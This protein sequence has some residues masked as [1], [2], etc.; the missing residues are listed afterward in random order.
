MGQ[1]YEC[2]MIYDNRRGNP[3]ADKIEEIRE[4][5]VVKN[6]YPSSKKDIPILKIDK[7]ILDNS[8][9]YAI[10]LSKFDDFSNNRAF[11]SNIER[12]A[13]LTREYPKKELL[14]TILDGDKNED[15]VQKVEDKLQDIPSKQV[16]YLRKYG[17]EKVEKFVL[18]KAPKG[19]IKKGT[20]MSMLVLAW[21]IFCILGERIVLIHD[22]ISLFSPVWEAIFN[23]VNNLL[24]VAGNPE[25]QQITPLVTGVITSAPISVAWL[26][27]LYVENK[28]EDPLFWLNIRRF[29]TSL[30]LLMM[31]VVHKSATLEEN[32]PME[33]KVVFDFER[34]AVVNLSGKSETI[35]VPIND[36]LKP[37]GE[38]W[39]EENG[40]E[41]FR[42]E[43][44]ESLQKQWKDCPSLQEGHSY[45]AHW[46]F[47]IIESGQ[48]AFDYHEGQPIVIE[49]ES[50]S[51]YS[52]FQ[53]ITKAL[54]RNIAES[55]GIKF[56]EQ[57]KMYSENGMEPIDINIGDTEEEECI[58]NTDIGMVCLRLKDVYTEKIILFGI[59]PNDY[60]ELKNKAIP[61][62]H[63]AV[64]VE[65]EY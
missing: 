47:D 5:K 39:L 48:K 24:N 34:V 65:F 61:S 7:Q 20:K 59:G 26:I 8:K 44:N 56:T 43:V 55:Y 64:T 57:F 35:L 38:F 54:L 46:N 30:L 60:T 16:R 62:G 29:I 51:E 1:Y 2:C 36:V 3:A 14:Y 50:S 52:D 53:P 21:T 63:V 33:N 25:V 19:Y 10:F 12:A 41:V 13:L 4:R 42:T 40:K 32:I 23:W 45:D 31:V 9:K 58:F 18:K 27:L 15:I 22:L 11:Y 28:S 49:I 37:S 6:I 17:P